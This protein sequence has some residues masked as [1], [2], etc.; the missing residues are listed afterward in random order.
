MF[1]DSRIIK[2]R[3]ADN[4]CSAKIEYILLLLTK[5]EGIF[6]EDLLEEIAGLI[7]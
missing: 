2:Q 5:E 6:Q 1:I 4:S 7:D 3:T